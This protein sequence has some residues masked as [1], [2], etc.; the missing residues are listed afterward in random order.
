MTFK[1]CRTS[2]FGGVQYQASSNIDMANDYA[3]KC[4]HLIFFE[5]FRNHRIWTVDIC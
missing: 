3:L 5:F 1:E 2:K 4:S